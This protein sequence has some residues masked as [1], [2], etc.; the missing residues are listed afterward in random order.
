MVF[1]L[2]FRFKTFY[3]LSQTIYRL[4]N[5][6]LDI[7]SN[8]PSKP[9]YRSQTL[10][11]P[12]FPRSPTSWDLWKQAPSGKNIKNNHLFPPTT[13]TTEAMI[14]KAVRAQSF[15]SFLLITDIAIYRL[16]QPRGRII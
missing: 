4:K 11:F 13:K 15:Q 16:N 2:R 5:T 14:M 1:L 6:I 12:N 10:K 9:V 8:I 7:N 3:V